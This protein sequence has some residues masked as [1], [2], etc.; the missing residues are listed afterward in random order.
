MNNSDIIELSS[1]SLEILKSVGI[2]KDNNPLPK[3]CPISNRDESAFLSTDTPV[4]T[5]CLNCGRG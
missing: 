4:A 5:L 2:F 1:F 3:C